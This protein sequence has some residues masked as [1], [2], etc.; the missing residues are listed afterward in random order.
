MRTLI[1][2][3]TSDT[4]RYIESIDGDYVVTVATKYGYDLFGRRYPEKIFHVRFDEQSLKEFIQSFGI[5]EVTDTTHPFAKEITALAKKVC[6]EMNIPYTDAMRRTDIETDYENVHYVDSH[7]EAVEY[8]RSR[9]FK[10]VLITTG[11]NNIDK[12]S[13]IAGICRARVLPYEKSIEKC[14]Q[15]G[16]EYKNIIAMQGPFSKEFN[17]AILREIGADALVTKMSGDPGGITEKIEACR[18]TGSAC[19]I[20]TGG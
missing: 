11:A 7:E 13:D 15:A 2:G 14:L 19:V 20:V 18:E 8:I 5:T 10:S 12:Y 9:E 4:H 3:G 17:T 1:L 6:A 16:F